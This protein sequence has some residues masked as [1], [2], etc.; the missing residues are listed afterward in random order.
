MKFF[1]SVI[2]FML[3]L[4]E[5]SAAIYGFVEK[6]SVTSSI[7]RFAFDAMDIWNETEIQSSWNTIQVDSCCFLNVAT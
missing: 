5:I 6:D 2:L 7:K 3:F 4:L 1:S